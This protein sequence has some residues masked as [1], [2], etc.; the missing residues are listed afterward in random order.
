[1]GLVIFMLAFLGASFGS[2][3]GRP[4]RLWGRRVQVAAAVVIILVGGAL[5]YAGINPGVWDRLIL[6]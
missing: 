4:L 2:A 3:L 5:I 6:S 1:M